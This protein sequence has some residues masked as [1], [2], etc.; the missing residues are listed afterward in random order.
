[1]SNGLKSE[2]GSAA[3]VADHKEVSAI[4]QAPLETTWIQAGAASHYHGFIG[5][6]PKSKYLQGWRK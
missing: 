4:I 3:V 6:L 5:G 2:M 1:M